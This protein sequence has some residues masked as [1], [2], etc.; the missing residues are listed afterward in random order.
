[1]KV[2]EDLVVELKEENLLEE[3]VIDRSGVRTNGN[4]NGSNHHESNTSNDFQ[5]SADFD[6]D[7][8]SFEGKRG[9][10]SHQGS[11]QMNASPE[12]IR[13][14]LSE[15]MSALQFVEYVLTAVEA[16]YTGAT[17]PPFDD[18]STKK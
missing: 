1:M 17:N 5:G 18:L 9:V 15:M 8:T 14:R 7:A 16:N 2:F 3:T 11:L 12:T 6:F 10:G 13:R 4:G